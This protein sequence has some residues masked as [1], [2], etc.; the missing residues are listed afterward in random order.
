MTVSLRLLDLPRIGVATVVTAAIGLGLP[1]AF[2]HHSRSTPHVGPTSATLD[3][4]FSI[5][6]GAAVGLALGGVLGALLVRRGSRVLS[7][8]LVGLLAYTF[9]LAP[10]LVATDDISLAEDLNA[11]GLA[12]LALLAMPLGASAAL[13]A[14]VGDLLT[15][16]RRTRDPLLADRDTESKKR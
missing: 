6:F 13:G 4:A 2:L 14:I 15:R 11:S 5:L 10:V 7:G 16:L 12:F 8:V 1:A 9:V 3:D